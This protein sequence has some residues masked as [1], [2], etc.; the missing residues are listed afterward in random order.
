MND[1]VSS[2]AEVRAF[3]L[4]QFAKRWGISKSTVYGL[5]RK[6]ELR[7]SKILGKTVIL[8]EEDKRFAQRLNDGIA[9]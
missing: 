7:L 5:A 4:D 6:G 3:S 2:N 1:V 8:A 9:A